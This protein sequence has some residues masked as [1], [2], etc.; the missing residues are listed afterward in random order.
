VFEAIVDD[1]ALK[2]NLDNETFLLHNSFQQNSQKN[3]WYREKWKKVLILLLL[4]FFILAA[5]LLF[6]DIFNLNSNNLKHKFPFS[7]RAKIEDIIQ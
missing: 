5:P 2:G 4:L 7:N 6:S 3:I 1:L